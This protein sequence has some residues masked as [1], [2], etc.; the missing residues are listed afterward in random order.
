MLII[1][2]IVG[3][4]SLIWN[5]Y[6]GG[7]KWHCLGRSVL[8]THFSWCWDSKQP[9][10]K[11]LIPVVLVRFSELTQ[12]F[13]VCYNS[14]GFSI[15]LVRLT[16]VHVAASLT[17]D[18][19]AFGK[20]KMSEVFKIFGDP[21]RDLHLKSMYLEIILNCWV[22]WSTKSLH[23]ISKYKLLSE[24]PVVITTAQIMSIYL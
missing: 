23:K 5:M 24:F 1:Q 3:I 2:W 7:S 9:Q 17:L 6:Q 16:C 8:D 19:W 13:H 4:A 21:H 15:F 12:T 10:N 11:Q 18:S 14:L 22:Y 20:L